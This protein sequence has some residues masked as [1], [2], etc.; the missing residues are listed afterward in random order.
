MTHVWFDVCKVSPV[1]IEYLF[2][3]VYSEWILAIHN[4]NS[5]HIMNMMK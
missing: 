4:M 3:N 5:I 2:P 1:T